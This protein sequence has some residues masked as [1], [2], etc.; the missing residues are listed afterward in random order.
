MTVEWNGAKIIRTVTKV[1]KDN[2]V[3][4]GFLILKDFTLDG[5]VDTGR[6]RASGST[7]VSFKGPAQQPTDVREYISSKTGKKQMSTSEDGVE[8]PSAGRGEFISVT[9]S[10]IDY[11]IFRE[12]DRPSLRNA[13][14]KNAP[15]IQK[16]FNL[17]L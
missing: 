16:L 1:T 10:N 5:K 12:L 6:H 15:V 17:N 2:V 14:E 7:A 9:G 8:K 4:A 3:R 11:A 13:L